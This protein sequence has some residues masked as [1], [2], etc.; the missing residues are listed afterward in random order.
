MSGPAYTRVLLRFDREARDPDR[1]RGHL[2]ACTRDRDG[3]L[4]LGTDELTTLSRFKPKAPGVFTKH[5]YTYL[6]D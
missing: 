4:W 6:S 2:S 3:H 5:N 1:L